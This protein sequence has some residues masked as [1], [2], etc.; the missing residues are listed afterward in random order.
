MPLPH[1]WRAA[2]RQ[3]RALSRTLCVRSSLQLSGKL[4]LASLALGG[5]GVS[6][7]TAG[8]GSGASSSPQPSVAIQPNSAQP[9]LSAGVQF[10]AKVENSSNSAVNWLV[11]Q[12][13][14]G[15][16]TV[17]TVSSSGY[18]TAPGQA[19]GVPVTVTAVLQ[20][21]SSVSASATVSIQGSLTISP[22]LAGVTISQSL[23]LQIAS[24]DVQPSQV[25]WS[26]DG[27]PNGSVS[28]GMIS[29]NGGTTTYAP[30]QS[31]GA[32]IVT[33]AL[34]ANPNVM[35]Q[36]TV[37]VTDLA[38]VLTWRNDNARSGIN[39]QE[40]ALSPTTVRPGTFGKLFSCSVDGYV[41]AQPLY[42]ANLPI[43]GNGTHNVVFVATENDSV[44]AFD[45]DD[46]SCVQRPLWK[47]SLI[48]PGDRAA[49]SVNL[50]IDIALLGPFI[51]I[52]GTPVIDGNISALYVVAVTQNMSNGQI[53]SHRLYALDLATGQPEIVSGGA[54]V[55]SLTAQQFTSAPENQR[56]ALLLDNNNLYVAF[57][58]YDASPYSPSGTYGWL[59]QYTGGTQSGN[60]ALEEV[61]AF[62]VEPEGPTG[63][64]LYGGV[65]GGGIWQSGGGPSADQSHDIYVATG[66]GSFNANLVSPGDYGDSILQLRPTGTTGTLSVYDSFTPCDQLLD[67]ATG[68][69]VGASAPVLLPDSAGSPSY[70]HLLIGA[71]KGGFVYVVSRDGMGEYCPGT[72]ISSQTIALSGPI[73]SSPLY[74]NHAV[75][76]APG[77]GGLESLPMMQGVLSTVPASNSTVMLGPQGAT[78]ALSW[79]AASNDLSTGVLWVIDTS[80]ALASTPGPAILRAFNPG[81]LSSEL[82]DSAMA[83]KNRDQ[84]GLAVKFTVPTVANGKVYVGT[85]SELDV[86]GLLP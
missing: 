64:P 67:A 65:V 54:P 26:V 12:T 69:D 11:N 75:Y 85:Q 9:F 84:A 48:P 37:Y 8:S 40:L 44:Y 74:W 38:G 4:F 10:T 23:A 43:P 30:P 3:C 14:N 7:S 28:A 51:G 55:P 24:A 45:A 70:P 6:C 19:P 17:G 59:F 33:A 47:T 76:V 72:S 63:N 61:G 27:A 62:T 20:S 50:G 1:S 79:D 16:S 78:P 42:V 5:V 41:Y 86:Y 18:Y 83:P 46:G 22:A 52:T 25:T 60:T 73:F 66:D 31:A 2:A 21:D 57:G 56:A 36:A 82:Y 80:G 49:L 15:D 35:G 58:S 13:P 68:T 53:S 32:H 34:T 77:N 39:G 29:L 71:S 81:D